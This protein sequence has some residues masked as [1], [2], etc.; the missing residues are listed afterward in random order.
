MKR[1]FKISV[2]SIVAASTA[3]ALLTLGGA[4]AAS[5]AVSSRHT[6]SVAAACATSSK[7]Y[8]LPK[9]PTPYRAGTSGSVTVATVN[10][11]TIR[12]AKVS[13]ARGWSSLVDSSSG[14]SVDIY[15]HQGK[16]TVKFEAEINDWGG[17]TV[18]VTTC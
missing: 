12:V 17:L 18:R 14:S 13:A 4:G 11:G 1:I 3:A 10:S 6:S 9:T 8:R 16:H 2:G 15:F 5:A 7:N